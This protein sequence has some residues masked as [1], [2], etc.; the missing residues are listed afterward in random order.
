MFKKQKSD[1]LAFRYLKF[2]NSEKPN[3]RLGTLTVENTQNSMTKNAYL[4][5]AAKS[6]MHFWLR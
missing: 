6:G 2:F 3:S 4:W 5:I 1:D